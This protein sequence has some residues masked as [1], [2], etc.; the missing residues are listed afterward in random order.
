MWVVTNASNGAETMTLAA[1]SLTL[2]LLNMAT[3]SEYP[4]NAI[5]EK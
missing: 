1:S 5:A 2:K 3:M 4:S